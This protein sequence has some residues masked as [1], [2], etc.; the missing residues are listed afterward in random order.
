MFLQDIQIGCGTSAR[1]LDIHPDYEP[2]YWAASTAMPTKIDTPVA[3]VIDTDI[4]IIGGGYTG[5]STAYHL[6]K[7]YGIRATV[8]EA[9]RVGWGCS[10][11]NGGFAMIGV[12]KDGYGNWIRKYG[13][14]GARQIFEFGREAVRTVRTVLNDNQIAAASPHEGWLSLAHRPNRIRE[15]KDTQHILKKVFAFD[16]QLLSGD[17]VKSKYLNS[18]EVHGALL[19]PEHFAIHPM[20][21]VQGLGTAVRKLGV[22][23]HE[24][25]R[26][27]K[28][29]QN[30]SAH[31]LHTNGGQVRAKN[32][33]IATGGYTEDALHKSVS[34]RLMN[35]LSNIIVTAPLTD[36]QLQA[37]NWKTHM[38]LVDSRMLRFYF[39]LLEDNRVMFGARGGLDD[40][41]D[42][43][44]HM[45]AWLLQRLGEQ[46]PALRG[47]NAPYFWRGMVDISRDKTP[48][49]GTSDDGSV[50]YALGY[51][52]TGV[53]ASTLCG[54]LLA[55][56][57][58]TR[59][60]LAQFPLVGEPLRRFEF[61]PLRKLYQ[62][63]A[64]GYYY[65][66]DEYL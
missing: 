17:E 20:R 49:L 13:E 5:L 10:G 44:A 59:E 40:R 8:I 39:R 61:S 9:N 36:Q 60:P 22:S 29:E 7:E 28:W 63:M 4:A 50:C 16:T 14:S 18:T 65:I 3:G 42:T 30:G 47:I 21:Y 31:V 51:T 37:C 54:K 33:V 43:D 53:A 32:V 27:Q 1:V 52:G 15:L 45:K 25:S 41:P 48:H 57:I 11:R 64:Y 38:M 24:K 62:R 12:G 46:F 58:A 35:V 6:A 26:V 66:K 23:I 56:Y 2:S 55:N 19:Y 34:G